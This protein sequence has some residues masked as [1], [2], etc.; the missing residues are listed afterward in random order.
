MQNDFVV[1]LL[2][3][4]LTKSREQKNKLKISSPSILKRKIVQ[5]FITS[6][7]RL[8]KGS[9]ALGSNLRAKR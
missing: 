2:N 7:E 4:L 6:E 9:S 8:S 1:K 5:K 3:Y